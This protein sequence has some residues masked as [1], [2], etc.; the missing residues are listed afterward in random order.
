MQ[1]L[2]FRGVGLGYRLGGV[3][4]KIWGLVSLSFFGVVMDSVGGP[5]V[6]VSVLVFFYRCLLWVISSCLVICLIWI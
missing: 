5:W 1:V 2:G 3:F 6:W 4:V